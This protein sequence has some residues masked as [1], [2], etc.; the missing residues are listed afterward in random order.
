MCGEPAPDA[1]N[2]PVSQA[3]RSS[4]R[5]LFCLARAKREGRRL[6]RVALRS[7]DRRSATAAAE[8]RWRRLKCKCQKDY[9]P[10]SMRKH[11]RHFRPGPCRAL[12]AHSTRCRARLSQVES[13]HRR[14]KDASAAWPWAP[15]T[16]TGRVEVRGSI[17]RR[18]LPSSRLT[19]PFLSST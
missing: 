12:R 8:R 6:C 11:Y 15:V 2:Y 10:C 17:R 18:H 4:Q 1:D 19:G 16:K 5:T 14:H 3:A 13:E 7:C 9:A